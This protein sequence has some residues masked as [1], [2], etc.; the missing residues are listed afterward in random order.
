M[1]T[2]T[3]DAD[4]QPHDIEPAILAE[5]QRIASLLEMHLAQEATELADPAPPPPDA[6]PMVDLAHRFQLSGFERDLLMLCAAVELDAGVAELVRSAS[7]SMDGRPS[8]ALAL[9]SLP[10]AHWDALVPD[11]PLRSWQLIQLADGDT[12]TSHRASIDERILHHLLGLPGLD[13]RLDGTVVALPTQAPLFPSHER[14]ARQLA[15]S[16]M[17]Q[18]NATLVNLHGADETTARSVATKVSELV[19]AAPIGVLAEALPGPGPA[20]HDLTRLLDREW[21]LSR[22]LAVICGIGAN[23]RC[24]GS[25]GSKPG[26][27]ALSV[28]APVEVLGAA[29]SRL[30]LHEAVDSPRPAER[31]E[32]LR[33]AVTERTGVEP[34][35]RL[36]TVIEEVSQ[37]HR[38][39]SET[40][41]SIGADLV[42]HAAHDQ[43]ERLHQLSRE[44]SR[45]RLD[46]LAQR[47]SSTASWDDVLAPG[48]LDL[49]KEISRQVKHRTRVYDEWG[50]GDRSSRGLG[51]TALFAGESGT[52]KTL[53]AEVI[54]NE[55][56][57]DLYRVDLA[58]T[59]SKYIGETEKNLSRLFDAAEG[60]GAVLLFDEADALFGKRTEVRVQPR[61]LRQPRS[62]LPPP[63]HGDVSGSGWSRRPSCDRISI[64]HLFVDCAVH[65]AVPVPDETQRA[66]IWRRTFPSRTPVDGLEPAAL[67]KLTIPGGSIW[68]I[69]LS[70]AFAAADDD[71][72]ITPEH[73]LSAAR[74]EYAEELTFDYPDRSG[75]TVMTDRTSMQLPSIEITID[76]VVLRGIA[77]GE[78]HAF[79][80]ALTARLTVL[81]EESAAGVAAW[82]SREE[83]SRRTDGLE[84]AS[85]SPSMLGEAI[86]S[87]VHGILTNGERS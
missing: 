24:I 64:E 12:L 69:A 78:Q 70:A 80:D 20:L 28:S 65:R 7:A 68:S 29:S 76:E 8:L 43:P 85:S 57:L 81:V 49:L 1:T 48:H 42:R 18:P 10:G 72:P 44:R 35:E 46:S 6:G 71:G 3:H 87:Q 26:A 22:R 63:A 17:S 16:L 45:T 67:A 59:V 21:M 39:N 31:R 77:P 55:L 19:G 62:R 82:R 53:A 61:S 60:S 14:A 79:A 74:T 83:S 38:L 75:G 50:F 86:A 51:V 2:T 66:E 32:L 11:R 4:A 9:A 58:A 37:R 36:S 23:P 54:A 13:R 41:T 33:R 15:E 84:L 5:I 27:V 30:V 25:G 56:S 34:D 40:I 47:I 52:G 73:V